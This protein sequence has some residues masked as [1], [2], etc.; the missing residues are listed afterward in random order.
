MVYPITVFVKGIPM[1]ISVML[2]LRTKSNYFNKLSSKLSDFRIFESSSIFKYGLLH[3][4]LLLFFLI[5]NM[6]CF[7]GV[8]PINCGSTYFFF[9]VW[10]LKLYECI[11][12][13]H[14]ILWIFLLISVSNKVKISGYILFLKFHK[15]FSFCRVTH[16][17]EKVKVLVAQSSLTVC[18][19]MDYI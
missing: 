5:R 13:Q 12:N 15:S 16:K 4:I 17:S 8:M 10:M 3:V 2:E 19:P 7:L 11:I 1:Y 9:L 18:N 14:M 6:I